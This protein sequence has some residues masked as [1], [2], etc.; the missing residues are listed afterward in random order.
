[1]ASRAP[2]DEAALRAELTGPGTFWRDVRVVAETGSSN[3]DL[4]TAAAGGA[5]EGSVLAAEVQTAGRGRLGRTWMSPP[6]AALTFSVLVR[7][8][9]VPVTSR[10]WVPLLAGVA[11]ACAL[12]DHAVPAT[13]K[14]PNDVL[15]A[16]AKVAGILAEQA[17]GAIVVGL[18]INV[19]TQRDELPVPTATSLALASDGPAPS[20]HELLVSVLGWLEHWYLRW[21]AAPGT[22]G[23][24]QACGLR[25]EYLRLSATVGQPVEVSLPGGQ[26]LAG[27]AQDVDDVGR[28]VVR[29]PSGPVTVSAGDVVHARRLM[30]GAQ[31][32]ET[33]HDVT[34]GR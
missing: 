23:D 9:A 31:A 14:W 30:T 28:L 25:P 33:C 21:T 34:Y 12:R 4:V 2:L 29:G 13:V 22:P 11:L 7:P 1:L 18:G 16:D 15:I 17:A 20:R 26:V 32:P 6:G 19:S 5:P 27:L 24:A 10:G 3:T 8:R